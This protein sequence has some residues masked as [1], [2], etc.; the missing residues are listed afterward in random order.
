MK[1]A[2]FSKTQTITIKSVGCVPS[3]MIR[4]VSGA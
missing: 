3:P 4:E 1:Q 2:I